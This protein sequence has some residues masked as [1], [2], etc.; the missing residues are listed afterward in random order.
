MMPTKSWHSP[1]FLRQKSTA[2]A[3]RAPKSSMPTQR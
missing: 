1:T 3:S 2:E